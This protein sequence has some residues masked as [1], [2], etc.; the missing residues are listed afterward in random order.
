MSAITQH[1]LVRRTQGVGQPRGW[2][3]SSPWKEYFADNRMFFDE[4]ARKYVDALIK[5]RNNED[6]VSKKARE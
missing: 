5:W 3:R 1:G 2:G 4:E 6:V